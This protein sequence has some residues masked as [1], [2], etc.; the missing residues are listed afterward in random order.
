M[1]MGI[2]S[3]APLAARSVASGPVTTITSTWRRTSSAA[4]PREPLEKTPLRRPG[5]RA[6]GSGLQPTQA[7]CRH[8]LFEGLEGPGTEGNWEEKADPKDFPRRLRVGRE[9]RHEDGEDKHRNEP[10]GRWRASLARV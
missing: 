4:R 8:P 2:V 1:T 7:P 3:V 10:S 5:S 9:R 6:Q